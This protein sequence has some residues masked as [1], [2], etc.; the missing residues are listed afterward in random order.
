MVKIVFR[1]VLV[2]IGV[3]VIALIGGLTYRSVRQHRN[4]IALSIHTQNRIEESL[5]I[6]I[7]GIDQSVQ[8]RGQDRS[9]PVVLMLHGGP[10]S[11]YVPFT[12]AFRAWEKYFTVVQWDQRGSGKTFGRNEGKKAGDLTIDRMAQDG[13]E[14]AEFISK[15]LH[16]H[17]LILLAHSWGTILGVTMV[18]RRPDLFYAYVGT[19]QIIDMPRNEKVTYDMV[20]DRVRASGDKKAIKKLE[21]IG[22]P[23]YK[24]MRS[25]FVKQKL[26]AETAPAIADGIF[27][28]ENFYT[29]ALFAPNYSLKDSYDFFAAIY[30]SGTKLMEELMSYDAW[31]LGGKFETPMF[32]FQGELDVNT[33]TELVEAYFHTIQAP[34][35]ELVLLKDCGHMAVFSKSDVFLNELITRVR[36]LAVDHRESQRAAVTKTGNPSVIQ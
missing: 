14:V 21:D 28:E 23:P 12:F 33:P 27:L 7:G 4:A 19:G 35:K 10:G 26:I 20:L 5:F 15:R 1:S 22:P 6:K 3:L 11:S 25:W 30:Y 2:V 9:N 17:R 34:E 18:Q 36:P 32:F 8:V 16:Q 24:D 13:I 29:A 31:R